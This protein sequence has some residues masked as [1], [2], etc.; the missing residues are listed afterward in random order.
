MKKLTMLLTF[1]LISVF[2]LSQ[3]NGCGD[4]VITNNPV[5]STKG[6]FVLYE[7]SYGVPSSCDYAFIDTGLDSVFGN[8]YQ[9][10]NS[11]ANLNSVPNGMFLSGNDLFIVS[12]GTYG[13]SGSMYRINATTNQLIHSRPY[14][15]DN[16]YNFTFANGNFYVTNTASNYVMVV[17]MNFNTLVDSI[18]VGYNPADIIFAGGNVFVGKQ[19][20]AF[21]KSLAVINSNNQVSKIFFEGAPVSI[22]HNSGKIYVSTYSYKKLFVV[23]ASTA[24]V[25]DSID[26]SI[27]QAGTGYVVSGDSRTLYVLGTDTAFQ[28]NLG[29]SI[30]KVDLVSKSIDPSFTINFTGFDDIYGIDYDA[31]ESKIYVANS[32]GGSVNGE[33]RVYNTSGVLLKTYSDI[34]GKFPRRFAFKY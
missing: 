34:G 33:V 16:P 14:I 17:D 18:S 6:V 28:Y 24:Q 19:S 32:K 25:T 10:S 8:V 31:V 9:N 11:G 30:Y 4:E 29:K 2:A 20:Y 1:V 15:G 26:I 21:E 22:A 7:G 12:Q 13:Q 23:D 5:T 3:F 27:P